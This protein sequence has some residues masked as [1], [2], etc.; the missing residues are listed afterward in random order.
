MLGERG[1]EQVVQQGGQESRGA[2]F[3]SEVERER[4]RQRG[5]RED[6]GV[7][8]RSQSGF[9]FGVAARHRF[10]LRPDPRLVGFGFG[11]GEAGNRLRRGIVQVIGCGGVGLTRWHVVICAAWIDDNR[12]AVKCCGE[13][14]VY[15]GLN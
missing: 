1:D 15:I 12:R 9:G 8:V 13:A 11:R 5:M 10:D 14:C 2:E 4:P 7:E 3:V 6:G